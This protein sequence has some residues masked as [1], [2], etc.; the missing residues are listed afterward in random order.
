MLREK[1]RCATGEKQWTESGVQIDHGDK[2]ILAPVRQAKE[3][4]KCCKIDREMN[5]QRPLAE[6]VQVICKPRIEQIEDR[7]SANHGEIRGNV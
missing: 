7:Q 6:T 1:R 3:Y 2:R 4:A 5:E